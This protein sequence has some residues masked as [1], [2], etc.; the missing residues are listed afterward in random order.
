MVAT[1]FHV[2]FIVF[3]K[4]TASPFGELWTG[5]GTGM[6]FPCCPL[7][8]LRCAC[9]CL[10]SILWPCHVM[11]QLLLLLG[12]PTIVEVL[13]FFS[14]SIF[15]FLFYFSTPDIQISNR[16]APTKVCQLF[17]RK[18]NFVNSFGH[19]TD[20]QPSPK[21]Y[22]VSSMRF[23]LALFLT[24]QLYVDVVSKCNNMD[25]V[26][27]QICNALVGL[28]APGFPKFGTFTKLS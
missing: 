17:R 2:V 26:L 23:W 4:E 25:Y 13:I 21:S 12:R 22:G 18:L 8:Q 24:R 9:Q 16:A 3:W 27:K 1:T 11:Y 19:L 14:C 6:S 28:I 10:A 7:S 15:L 20:T 5:V